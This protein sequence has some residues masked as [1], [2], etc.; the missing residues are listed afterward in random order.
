LIVNVI[1]LLDIES[2]EVFALRHAF[3]QTDKMYI[4]MMR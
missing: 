3:F 4:G 2:Q 1:P